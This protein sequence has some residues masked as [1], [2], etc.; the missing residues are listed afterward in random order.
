[1]DTITIIGGGPA[2]YVAAITA[3]RQ[4]KQVVLIEER[5]LG[6]TCLN[7]GCMPTKSLLESAEV[8]EKVK[9]AKRFGVQLPA[10]SVEIDWNGVQSNKKRIVKKL[11][12]GIGYLM[13]RNKIQ[14]IKGKASFLTDRLLKIDDGEKQE[15][16]EVDKVIIAAGSEPIAL[17]FAPFDSEWVIDSRQAMSLPSIP[18]SL[19]IVGGGVIGCEFASIYSRMG[20]RVAIIEMANQLIPK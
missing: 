3:A 18:P 10:G 14:V 12:L 17:P 19:L 15:L 9:G 5:E 11:V 13:K 1:M 2:G 7:E 20:T 4:G 6:G 16:V 8:L